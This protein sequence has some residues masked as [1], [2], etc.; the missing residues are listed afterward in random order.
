MKKKGAAIDDSRIVWWTQKIHVLG[1]RS[2]GPNASHWAIRTLEC[3]SARA[4][5]FIESRN[6]ETVCTAL[7][8]PRKFISRSLA[9]LTRSGLVTLMSL[10]PVR[11]LLHRDRL[12][13]HKNSAQKL[14]NRIPRR[15]RE[16]IIKEDKFMCG[17][18]AAELAPDQLEIDHIIPLSL[19]GADQPGN[20]VALCSKHNRYKSHNF[21][22][23]FIRFYRGRRVRKLGVRFKNGYFW[24]HINGTTKIVTREQ[25]RATGPAT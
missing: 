5:G 2:F 24:P 18:C 15:F 8:V 20:W 23:T 21:N 1:A 9:L 25:C 4:D 11:L 10:D 3:L 13:R 22:P 12:A 7:G 16:R 19:L 14:R 6:I 17:H